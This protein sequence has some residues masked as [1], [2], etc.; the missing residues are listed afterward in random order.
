MNNEAQPGYIGLRQINKKL[1]YKTLN[2]WILLHHVLFQLKCVL[3]TQTIEELV[4]LDQH[5]TLWNIPY[6]VFPVTCLKFDSLICNLPCVLQSSVHVNL[7][8]E[9]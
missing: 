6:Q 2:S 1:L 7:R 8:K 9:T 3:P 5:T 4:C